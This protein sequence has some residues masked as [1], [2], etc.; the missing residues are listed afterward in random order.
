MWGDIRSAVAMPDE[1]LPSALVRALEKVP[2]SNLGAVSEYLCSWGHRWD[3]GGELVP[4]AS[5]M[6]AW[7][8]GE[9]LCLLE[10][11]GGIDD[12]LLSTLQKEGQAASVEALRWAWEGARS[13]H[14]E[15]KLR[16][17]SAQE[18]QKWCQ[19]LE[20]VSSKSKP[21]PQMVSVGTS[22]SAGGVCIDR[23]G[24][25]IEWFGMTWLGTSVE[26]GIVEGKPWNGEQL[27]SLFEIMRGVGHD[28]LH[29][30]EDGFN[31]SSAYSLYN[32]LRNSR[33]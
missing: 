1:E 12:E 26:F 5:L 10:C 25:E 20:T 2:P 15:T 19:L 13:S 11:I 23:A 17:R 14:S 33:Q 8:N 22:W 24:V 27:I 6:L 9:H 30:S 16:A 18:F 32:R 21:V 29:D 4:F 7:L 3:P 28:I 31:P